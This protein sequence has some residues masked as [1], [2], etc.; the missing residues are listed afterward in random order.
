M[1]DDEYERRIWRYVEGRIFDGFDDP[2]HLSPY[3]VFPVPPEK[4]RRECGE[5]FGIELPHDA[6]LTVN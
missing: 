3:C 5:F 1:I 4:I 2:R 6:R